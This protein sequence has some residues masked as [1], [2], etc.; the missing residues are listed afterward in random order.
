MHTAT[1]AS[2]NSTTTTVRDRLFYIQNSFL[3]ASIA[4]TFQRSDQRERGEILQEGVEIAL[5][6]RRRVRFQ[7][8]KCLFSL[9][10]IDFNRLIQSLSNK[11]WTSRPRQLHS[12]DQ[13]IVE[14]Q[15]PLLRSP[16]AAYLDESQLHHFRPSRDNRPRRRPIYA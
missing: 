2:S 7:S 16:Y 13:P 10:M 14:Q 9:F 4:E 11:R 12:F 3:T 15:S 1:A 5:E 6:R 8:G